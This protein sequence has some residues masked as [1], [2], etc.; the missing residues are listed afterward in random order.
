[1]LEMLGAYM[2]SLVSHWLR[3]CVYLV[4]KTAWLVGDCCDVRLRVFLDSL[5][6]AMK[7]LKVEENYTANPGLMCT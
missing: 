2:A 7:Q 4:R 5:L 3:P 6:V 1:M